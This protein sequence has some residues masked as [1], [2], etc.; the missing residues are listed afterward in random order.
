MKKNHQQSTEE[1]LSNSELWAINSR[2]DAARDWPTH[3]MYFVILLTLFIV[4]CNN[5]YRITE[6]GL[7]EKQV[8]I[9]LA[10][11]YY[12]YTRC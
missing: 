9:E 10:A 2:M 5:D 7:P 3:G 6:M 8:L 12:T 1:L 4:Q 11:R